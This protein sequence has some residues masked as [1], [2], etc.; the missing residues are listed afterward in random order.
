MSAEAR[1]GEVRFTIASI[2]CVACVPA[3]REGLKRSTGIRE[4]TALPML[5]K[6]VVKFDSSKV[7]EPAVKDS[8]LDVAARAGFKGMV[9][10]P[11][12][13]RR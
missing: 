4:V 8:I 3:F 2:D 13:R 11:T 5:N 12:E 7:G 1:G 9:V 6:L 10:F